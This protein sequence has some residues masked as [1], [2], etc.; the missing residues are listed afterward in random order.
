M[1]FSPRYCIFLDGGFVI[2]KLYPKLGKFPD[3]DD[4]VNLCD[5]IARNKYLKDLELLRIYFYHA[6]P[7]NKTL[8]N[9]V[10]SSKI[11]LKATDTYKH[12]TR[13]LNG[14]E[15]KPNFALRLGELASTGN[16][17]I[18]EANLRQMINHK[19]TIEPS[20]IKPNIVQK[21]V[22]LRLGLDIGR[23]ALK[24]LVR[25]IVVVTG[26][27]DLVP[28]FKFARREGIRVYLE[29]LQHGVN[30]DLRIHSDLILNV[31]KK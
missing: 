21:G 23:H 1:N 31:W 26:D 22:D 19:R 2:E 27:S 12:T 28:A 15:I 13:L 10:D 7:L 14:L 8:Y 5:E 24:E 18:R 20:D 29:H 3:A 11:D 30:N 6:R 9:P 25:A 16:W 17:R 4:V